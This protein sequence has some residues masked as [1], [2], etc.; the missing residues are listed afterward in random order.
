MR[1]HLTL[2]LLFAAAQAVN[3]DSMLAQVDA[4]KCEPK[5]NPSG[6]DFDA[7]TDHPVKMEIDITKDV[8]EDVK[9][10]VEEALNEQ[11]V[12]AA[13]E[14]VVGPDAADALIDEVI[15]PCLDATIADNLINVDA[16]EGAI[17]ML[18]PD[19][20]VVEK[21]PLPETEDVVT[22]VMEQLEVNHAGEGISMTSHEKKALTDYQLDNSSVTKMDNGVG[23]TVLVITAPTRKVADEVKETV[24]TQSDYSA[25]DV[26]EEV[27][28]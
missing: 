2:A 25:E 24:A 12:K 22:A 15:T 11:G 3:I 16:V 4:T 21:D 8:I 1:F 18:N 6:E 17:K 19:E 26:N 14:A 20:K 7:D 27:T 9:P 23:G 10:I 28:A 13:L 5:C